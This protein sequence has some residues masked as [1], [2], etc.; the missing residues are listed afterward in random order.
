MSYGTGWE[1]DGN[2]ED[3]DFHLRLRNPT[4]LQRPGES[5]TLEAYRVEGRFGAR[6]GW[7]QTRREH[8]GWGPVRTDGM[9]L[10]WMQVGDD[11]YLDPGYYDDAG[12][13]EL[14]LSRSIRDQLNGW[15]LSGKVTVAGGLA[16]NSDGLAAATGRSDLDEFYGRFLLDARAGRT[17]A[18]KWGVAGRF[19]AGVSTSGS[20]AVKQRQ[21]YLAGADPME[22]FSNPFLRSSGAVFVRPDVYYN[23]PGGAG[24]RGFDP[25][26]S[27]EAVLG[28]SAEVERYLVDRPRGKLFRRV[29]VAVFGDAGQ[30]LFDEAANR[31]EGK[32]GTLADAG[33]G[34]RATHMVGQ[35]MVTTRF[36]FPLLVSRPELAQDATPDDVAGFRWSFSFSPAW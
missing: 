3:L 26:L 20:P 34:L 4:A 2:V 16:Y 11:R 32:L 1:S 21:V 35:T 10:S 7:E 14:A 15:R 23:A 9:W 19:Y 12:T 18:T 5:Q 33:L 36:D 22:Q 30:V 13:V 31:P 29:S 6:L 27:A 17:L 24:L 8:L 28:L 25:R